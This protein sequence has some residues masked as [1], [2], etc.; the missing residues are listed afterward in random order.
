MKSK[1]VAIIGAGLSGLTCAR[2]LAS[3]G[4]RVTLFDKGRGVS[5]RMS[6]RRTSDPSLQFDHG[7][8]Y[9]TARHPAFQ[10]QVEEWMQQDFV[11]I[12]EGPF[13][14]LEQ[15]QISE[16]PGQGPR[17][18]GNPAMNALCKALANDL[19][20][21]CSQRVSQFIQTGSGWQIV[22]EDLSSNQFIEQPEV[23]DHIVLAI[24]PAQAINLLPENSSLHNVCNTV[25]MDP[26]RCVMLAFE[27]SLSVEFGAAFVQNSPLRWIACEN[28]KPGRNS[29]Y[30][31]WTLH[32]S[33]EWSQ[34]YL[35]ATHETVLPILLDAFTAALG[36][37]LPEPVHAST[38]RWLYAIPRNPLSEG[39]FQDSENQIT[40]CGDWCHEARVEGAYMSGL[41]AA[42]RIL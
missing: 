37:S 24:P 35:D 21:R 34:E 4:H 41:S 16:A 1:H 36:K 17:Y 39:S 19:E 33:S 23:F 13:V 12:W 3:K 8:Q 10:Q 7:A 5:G 14:S 9:F 18:V 26:C 22:A 38:H 31:C 27:S 28:S 15:G 2:E 40:I 42:D 30:E 25:I 11:T 32:A 29:R 20:I 6:V